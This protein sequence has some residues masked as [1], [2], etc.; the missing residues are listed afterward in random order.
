[1]IYLFLPFQTTIKAMEKRNSPRVIKRLEV[2]F[3][4]GIENTAITSDLSE[5]GLFIRTNRGSVPG[6]AIDLKLNLP[7]SRELFLA[8]KV[9]RS[10][11]SMAGLTGNSESGMGIQLI[12]PPH[13]YLNYI[14]SI[15]ANL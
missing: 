13:D 8:G 1:M 15:S 5:T 7:N 11:K 14:H 9:I 10:M 2:K 3:H 6:S 12:N 4:T